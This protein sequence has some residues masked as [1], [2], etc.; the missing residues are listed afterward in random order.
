M[1]ILLLLAFFSFGLHASELW[2]T[3]DSPFP[4]RAQIFGADVMYDEQTVAPGAQWHWSN[5]NVMQGPSSNP[6]MSTTPFT[7]IWYCARGGQ[8]YGTN[9]NIAGGAWVSAQSSEGGKICPLPKKYNSNTG[10][11]K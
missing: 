2:V 4:L 9:T 3:N 10:R 6:N 1:R 11:A 7:V 5:D 8:P